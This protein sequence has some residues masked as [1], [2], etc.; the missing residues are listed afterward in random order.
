VP[1]QGITI[2]RLKEIVPPDDAFYEWIDDEDFK[3]RRAFFFAMSDCD[4]QYLLNF[5]STR[6]HAEPTVHVVYGGDPDAGKVAKS[7][8]QFLE[9]H[10][11]TASTPQV[12]WTET[13]RLTVIA[14]ET[15][16][17][18]ASYC[19]PYRLEQILGRLGKKLTLFT[20]ERSDDGEAFSKTT[21]PEPLDTSSGLGCASIAAFRPGPGGTFALHIQPKNTDAIVQIESRQAA[22]GRWKNQESHGVPIYVQFESTDRKK[23]EQLR[24]T[25]FGK[26]V[27]AKAADWD[28]TQSQLESK[29]MSLPE[30]DRKA[31]GMQMFLE[32]M[33]HIDFPDLPD[34]DDMD[35]DLAAAF[36]GIHAKLGDAV[37]KAQETVA[38]SK[39]DPELQKLMAKMLKETRE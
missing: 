18:S 29:M 31:A 36:K 35:P 19:R 13:S 5:G 7:L 38:K 2:Y 39:V 30:E 6:S 3:D 9:K 16:D 12:D 28:A 25:L 34:T 37:K 14:Q 8:E 27:A 23:L 17:M 33:K 24:E 22:E 20:H 32:G 21:I 15:L 10:F 26:K 4:G 11:R 1:D